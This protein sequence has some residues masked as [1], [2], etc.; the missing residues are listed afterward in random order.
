MV[1]SW[2]IAYDFLAY[3]V[4]FIAY[5]LWV[6]A[7]GFLFVAS[8]IVRYLISKLPHRRNAWQVQGGIQI[9]FRVLGSITYL[10]DSNA[11]YALDHGPV[12]DFVERHGHEGE[13]KKKRE[14]ETPLP[15]MVS[16]RE[17]S[18]RLQPLEGRLY[19][20]RVDTISFYTF[21]QKAPPTG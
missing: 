18:M 21:L 6:I 1:C 19:D 3:C 14:A 16:G 13:G 17:M 8:D 4:W 11:K 12:K 9:C 15:C 20:A 5:D 10:I 7:Y 2:V